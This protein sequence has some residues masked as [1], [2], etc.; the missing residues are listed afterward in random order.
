M[1]AGLLVDIAWASCLH[2]SE[3]A[4]LAAASRYTHAEIT[5]W[6]H[7]IWDIYRV[8]DEREARI[9]INWDR[10]LGGNEYS[11]SDSDSS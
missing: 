8:E 9:L 11:S 4:A 5:P 2:L 6:L 3:L 1:Q 7:T 10:A